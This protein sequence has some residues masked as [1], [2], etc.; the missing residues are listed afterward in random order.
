MNKP[1]EFSRQSL[2]RVE[3]GATPERVFRALTHD[4]GAWWSKDFF[5]G[6]AN[7]RRFVLD[8]KIGG[9]VY[10]DWGDGQG[11]EWYRVVA[12][13]RNE[14]LL[15]SGELFPDF[16]GPALLQ[17]DFQLKSQDSGTLLTLKESVLGPIADGT[18]ESLAQGWNFLLADCLKAYLER[19]APPSPQLT[20]RA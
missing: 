10:E 19:P 15:L 9:S 17:E 12:I 8:A 20:P 18:V 1:P 16:G 3:I 13:K 6:G 14:R 2:Y 7:T 11:L 4:I 5:V